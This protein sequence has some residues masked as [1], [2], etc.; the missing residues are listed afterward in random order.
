MQ[1]EFSTWLDKNE[2]CIKYSMTLTMI[3][4]KVCN[5]V[6]NTKS[7]L[8]CYL[9]GATSKDFN[10]IDVI[11]QKEVNENNLRFGLSTLHAWIRF[12]ECCLH[13][14][15]RLEIKKWQARTEEEKKMLKNAKALFKR[16]SVWN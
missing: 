5:A 13:L 3:D 16:N 6:S 10:N 9:C 1:T 14:S 2:V 15:Y 11:L 8:R 4:N 7:T 12:F